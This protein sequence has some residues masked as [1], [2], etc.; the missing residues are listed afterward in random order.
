MFLEPAGALGLSDLARPSFETRLSAF[1]FALSLRF[2]DVCP[3]KSR[4]INPTSY[5]RKSPKK[6]VHL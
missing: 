4:R 1:R 2:T 3:V 6:W 5:N